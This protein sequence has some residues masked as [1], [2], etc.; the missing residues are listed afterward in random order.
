MEK[1]TE[2]TSKLVQIE[3]VKCA[4]EKLPFVTVLSPVRAVKGK[5]RGYGV[6]LRCPSCEE[7]GSCGKKQEPP[8][9]VS[10]VHPTEEA[11]LQELLKR[12]QDRHVDCAE[13]VAK[14]AAAD[15]VSAATVNPDAPNVLQAMMKLE[16]ANARAKTANKVALEAEKEKDAAEQA[17]AELKRQLQPKRARSDDHAGDAHEIPAEVDNWD[18]RDHRQQAT[19]VQNRRNVQVGSRQ[20]QA[21]PRTGTDG[22]LHHTR[23][24]LVGWISYWSSGD[25]ALAVDILVVLI[26]TLGLTEL[27]SDALASRKQKEADTNAKI[28]DLFKDALDEIKNCRTEQQRVEFHIALACVMPPREAQ[29]SK[30]GWIKPICDR[31]GLKRGKRSEKNGARP[32]ASEQAVET[33]AIFNKDRE[34]LA[35]PVKVG[36]MVLSKGQL[37]ELTA[38]GEGLCGNEGPSC[39][40]AF[41]AGTVTQ[42][43]KYSTM[44]GIGKDS[45]RLQRPPPSLT[46]GGRAQRKD[47]V[48][49]RTRQ[50]VKLHAY[51][52]C[53]E[54]PCKRDAMRKQV[55]PRVWE[56]RQALILTCSKD[57][58][59]AKFNETHPNLLG[60]TQYFMVLEEEVWNLKK[61]Y[62]ETC[63]CKTCFN[64]R[65]FSEGLAVVAKLLEI[66]L[67]PPSNQDADESG[68]P[69]L[70]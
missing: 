13:A 12:L 17:V 39:V 7:Y 10:S 32:Y 41:R 18:L 16:Q 20:N 58:L 43:H 25:S 40:L 22:F 15:A 11:C 64:C 50:V 6:T 46:P 52:T 23:L 60:V 59:W 51:D 44:Y 56:H 24:G 45:A 62:R 4:I 42:E 33:R 28:V 30:N 31:L 63:L 9:H 5:G 48:S 3:E 47:T 61:A 66:L 29:G 65:L 57:T 36:D 67:V 53:A 19:R 1:G 26:N 21:K 37:C 54:S 49:E 68:L 70:W 38:I 2:D 35:Q 69:R 55:G 8:V 14:K 27:V 34:L